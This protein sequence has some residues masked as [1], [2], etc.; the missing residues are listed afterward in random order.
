MRYWCI[1]ILPILFDILYTRFKLY[2]VV[3]VRHGAGLRGQKKHNKQQ[4]KLTLPNVIAYYVQ[5][6]GLYSRYLDDPCAVLRDSFVIIS[7]IYGHV[8]RF[9]KKNQKFFKKVFS[10]IHTAFLARIRPPQS[11]GGR[12]N[13]CFGF[14]PD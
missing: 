14:A 3:N 13:I 9:F 11:L 1:Y 5:R 7:H 12:G 8:K 6:Y 4:P 2:A 10:F